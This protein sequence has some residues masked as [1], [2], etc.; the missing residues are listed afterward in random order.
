VETCA[1]LGA[2][3]IAADVL[4]SDP[5]MEEGLSLNDSRGVGIKACQSTPSMASLR[6]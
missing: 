4:W 6:Q 3:R 2:S 1:G 5:V